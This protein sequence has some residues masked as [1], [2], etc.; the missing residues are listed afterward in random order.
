MQKITNFLMFTGRAEEAMNLYISLFDDA[1]VEFIKR[2]EAGQGGAEGSVMQAKFTLNGQ[3]FICIDSP[4][5]HAFTFTP[6]LSL[7]INCE[8][9]AE[10][11][12]LFNALS[13]G[14]SILMPLGA[15]PFGKKY[16]WV[17]DRFGVSWQVSYNG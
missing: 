3:E 2:Y 4:P 8:S 7:F 15:Y 5:V 9:E 10:V 14:G 12:K 13:A 1:K 11:D 6:A 17:N 16:A